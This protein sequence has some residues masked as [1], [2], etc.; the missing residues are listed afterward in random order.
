MCSSYILQR[1]GVMNAKFKI[2][3]CHHR[4]KPVRVMLVFLSGEDVVE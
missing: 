3:F 1:I 4:E 2:T